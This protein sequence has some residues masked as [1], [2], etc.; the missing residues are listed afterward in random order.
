M[1]SFDDQFLYLF[2][3]VPKC[4]GTTLT[5]A[6]GGHI[7]ES[8][9]VYRDPAGLTREQIIAGI[10]LELKDRAIPPA[11]LRVIHGHG[12]FEGMHM[13]CPRQ[14]RYF[15]FVREAAHRHVSLY[16]YF[17]LIA[18]TPEHPLQQPYR[19]FVTS[20]NQVLEYPDWLEARSDFW[21]LMAR[22][23]YYASVDTIDEPLRPFPDTAEFE[24]GHIQAVCRFLDRMFFVGLVE[25]SHEDLAYI[26]ETLR[27]P[28]EL[29]R[30]NR[31]VSHFSLE[32]NPS[33]FRRAR[34]LNWMDTEVYE[35]ALSLRRK[36]ASIPS[37]RSA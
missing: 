21:N 9:H 28:G 20:D 1:R 8:V 32:K 30:L 6:I 15:T 36:P 37:R 17:R 7:P 3:H 34:Y 19:E 5:D 14:P 22:T 27:I 29:G 35:Y 23:L 33:V 25:H 26:V 2:I 4:L 18:N 12:V 10:L 13:V 16:N 11:R 31:S 24:D